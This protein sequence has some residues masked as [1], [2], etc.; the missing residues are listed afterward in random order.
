MKKTFLAIAFTMIGLLSMS[1]VQRVVTPRKQTDSAS[2]FRPGNNSNAMDKRKMMRELNITKEQRAK[3][4]EYRQS[5]ITA[6]EAISSDDK[7]TTDEKAM[8]LRMLQREQVKNMQQ[9]LSDEQLM[10]LKKLRQEKRGR[11]T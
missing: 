4:K 6:K 11:K 7:L 10:K 5:R 8:K 1:Q 3:L 2:N 9:I